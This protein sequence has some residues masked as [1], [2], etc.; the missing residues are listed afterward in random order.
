MKTC[1]RCR[2]GRAFTLLELLLVVLIIGILAALLLPVLSKASGRGKRAQC[3]SNL[4][5]I[6]LAFHAF[7]HEHEDKFPFQVPIQAGGTMEFVPKSGAGDLFSAFRHFQALS[8]DL[9]TPKL[10]ICPADPGHAVAASFTNLSITNVSYSIGV[11]AKPYNSDFFLAGDGWEYSSLAIPSSSGRGQDYTRT[12]R[13]DGVANLL[14]ADGHVEFEKFGTLGLR[15]A[16]TKSEPPPP[17]SPS[18]SSSSPATAP[19]GSADS[20]AGGGGTGAGNRGPGGGGGARSSGGGNSGFTALQT[21]FQAQPT[22]QAT[23]PSATPAVPGLN[24]AAPIPPPALAQVP[25]TPLPEMTKP[26]TNRIA[27]DA[28]PMQAQA[29]PIAPPEPGAE[30]PTSVFLL[31]V[32]PER[33]WYCWVLFLLLSVVAAVLLGV[34][35]QRRRRRRQQQQGASDLATQAPISSRP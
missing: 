16:Q 21:F 30:P 29:P 24:V 18:P 2:P 14:F 12:Y 26:A 8:N 11:N 23:P 19:P 20:A 34:L 6:G 5:Q 4:R 13:H 35:I 3:V 32:Q 28:P 31:L 25:P 1:R 10:L 9:D 15:L 27:T 22:S 33:C 17:T 7:A